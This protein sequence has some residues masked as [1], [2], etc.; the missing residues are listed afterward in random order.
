M[1]KIILI[2]DNSE[3]TKNIYKR[4]FQKY[5][6][7]IDIFFASTA[8]EAITLFQKRPPD[9][10]IIETHVKYGSAKK[11]LNKNSDKHSLETGLRLA[12]YIFKIHPIPI[13]LTGKTF[14]WPSHLTD[15][16]NI[17]R[18]KT[19]ERPCCYLEMRNDILK[20]IGITTQQP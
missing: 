19:Y 14:S 3:E 16:L 7:Q 8:G 4:I 12:E 6:S 10:A 9:F 1:K 5:Q 15:R 13:F 18:I 17:N 11:T 2:V 20:K